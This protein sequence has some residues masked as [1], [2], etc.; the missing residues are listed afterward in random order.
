MDKDLQ[1]AISKGAR[2]KKTVT[3]DRSAPVFDSKSSGGGAGAGG[4]SSGGSG[5]MSGPLFAKGM[6]QL[7]PT[8][9]RSD[10]RPNASLPVKSTFAVPSANSGFG[11]KVSGGP[12]RPQNTF[13]NGPIPP[14]PPRE[15]GGGRPTPRPSFTP[16]RAP[17]PSIT[18]TRPPPP[19]NRGL[20]N[21][22]NPTR[23]APPSGF[24]AN[25]VTTSDSKVSP[26]AR[27]GAPAHPPN[28]R[29]TGQMGGP[30]PP[31][32]NPNSAGF[33]A[34]APSFGSANRTTSLGGGGAM[35]GKI[36]NPPP[37]IPNTSSSVPAA[38]NTIS[39]PPA[40]FTPQQ[41]TVQPPLKSTA[42]PPSRPNVSQSVP[43]NRGNFP[44]LPGRNPPVKQDSMNLP[45]PPAR[46]N[47]PP[48]PPFS[49][50]QPSR[51]SI[52][53]EV[54]PLHS[55]QSN[56][57]RSM[58]P[59][60][61]PTSRNYKS[62]SPPPALPSSVRAAP[63]LPPARSNTPPLNNPPPLP[64]RNREAAT[65]AFSPNGTGRS[66]P[67]PPASSS[68]PSGQ[69]L[70]RRFN[71]PRD[72]PHPIAFKSAPKTY[73]SHDQ[74]QGGRRGPHM[75]IPPPLVTDP[76]KRPPPPPPPPPV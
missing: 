46:A 59:P 40:R 51:N 31:P 7:R 39:P 30:R 21:V 71:F 54:S 24:K 67:P 76:T 26:F 15:T 69:E 5:G 10:I 6:P 58:A 52:S 28:F 60:P 20:P 8:G 47:P 68:M 12:S 37:N 17:G 38:Q 61:P 41:K 1:K 35:G 65:R 55:F 11:S 56:R 16:N 63:P 72:L 23:P 25:S 36:P 43:V 50:K 53:D 19:P 70:D 49:S 44:A 34:R 62:T 29:G 57:Q 14:P 18:N 42:P 9:P 22:P 27:P 74:D 73:P 33:S 4:G 32:P 13:E 2:L 48:P 75:K 66:A 3:N 45:P 64:D